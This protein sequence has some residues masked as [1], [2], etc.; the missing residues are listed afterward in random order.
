MERYG[1]GQNP[2]G[3]REEWMLERVL[4]GEVSPQVVGQLLEISRYELQSRLRGLIT[5]RAEQIWNETPT[6]RYRDL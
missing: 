5:D 6:G 3:R 1:R 4:S 2:P